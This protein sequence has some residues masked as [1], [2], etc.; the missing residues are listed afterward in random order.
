MLADTATIPATSTADASK[1]RLLTLGSLDGRTK[2]ARQVRELLADVESDLGG[3]HQLTAAQRQI[4]LR[5]CVIGAILE[6]QETGWISGDGINLG[7]YLPAANAQRRLLESLGLKRHARRVP[8]P[9][10]HEYVKR[11]D[12]AN[13]E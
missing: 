8:D 13:N 9:S 6:S 12:A 2:A 1:L 11:H 7:D 3:S 5:A 10:L 4:A